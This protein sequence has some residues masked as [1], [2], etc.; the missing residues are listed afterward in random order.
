MELSEKAV[1]F[2]ND[3]KLMKNFGPYAKYV[4]SLYARVTLVAPEKADEVLDR[5]GRIKVRTK[6]KLEEDDSSICYGATEHV[7]INGKRQSGIKLLVK[8]PAE[9]QDIALPL[10]SVNQRRGKISN[11]TLLRLDG[12]EYKYRI[13]FYHE[14][15]HALS[16]ERP[17]PGEDEP[18]HYTVVTGNASFGKYDLNVVGKNR[19]N[20]LLPS[21][22]EEGIVEDWASD[23]TLE[24]INNRFTRT[25]E[26]VAII[27]YRLPVSFVTCWNL[28][29]N[30]QLRRE[31]ITGIEDDTVDSEKTYEFKM[32]M[33]RLLSVT[34]PKLQ[35]QKYE[36]DTDKI[37]EN[38]LSL[39]KY[40]DA[41]FDRKA[42]TDA[43]C[44]KYDLSMAY[45]KSMRPLREHMK[46]YAGEKEK[47][48]LDKVFNEVEEKL[49][50]QIPYSQRHEFDTLWYLN[51]MA[52]EGRGVIKGDIKISQFVRWYADDLK[53]YL[54]KLPRRVKQATLE[55][56][57]K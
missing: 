37:A 18:G 14:M 38:Y 57:N 17:R 16:A 42:H 34:I 1:K 35:E 25:S 31:F 26:R 32:Q 36:Y 53:Y 15:L 2:F 44:G 30:N 11:D 40:C 23:L 7:L 13:S 39:I 21:L 9:L 8:R 5:L 55:S 10:T 22:I 33:L 19:K 12:Y 48:D 20:P 50:R 43:E 29:S 47:P 28:C 45:L 41:N 46:Q 51:Q 54:T 3:P 4:P 24:D 56:L 27:A 6:P 49:K 52:R